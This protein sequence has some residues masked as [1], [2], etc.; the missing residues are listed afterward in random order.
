MALTLAATPLGN[1]GDASPRLKSAIESAEIIAAE[2][3]RRFHRLCSDIEVTFTGRV[4]SFFDGNETARTEE[5]LQLLREG[6]NVLVVSDAGMPTISDPGFRLMR[7]AIAENIDVKVVPGPSA[8][9]MAIALSGL[10]TDRFS[11]EGFLPRASGARKTAL[12]L[13][14]FEERTMVFFEAPHRLKESLEDV[15]EVFGPNRKGAICREMTKTY[16]ETIRGNAEELVAWAT[17]NEILGEITL[18]IEG[19]TVGSAAKTSTEMVAR[20]REFEAAGMDRKTAIAT[21][22]DEFDLPKRTVY[23]AVVDA[24]KMGT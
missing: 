3:S 22:A 8:P 1:P 4:I 19:A 15:L 20:V 16:E 9:T 6:K 21:V 2:D 11:F 14:R 17:A 23:A 5:V 7:D 13:L 12:E 10:P 18:V 24:N